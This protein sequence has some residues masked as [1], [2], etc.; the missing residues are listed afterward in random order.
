MRA[1]GA[2]GLLLLLAGSARAHELGKLEHQAL[3]D[4][5]AL[6]GLEV[7]PAPEGK[8]IAQVQVVTLEVFSARDWYFQIFNV[9]HR[10][11]REGMIRREALFSAGQPYDQALVDETW[12][13]LQHPDLSSVVV[14]VPVKSP[15]P[16][17]VDVLIVTRDVWSLRLNTEFN[18][19]QREVLALSA[20]LSENNLFGWR[21]QVALVFDM[22]QGS[23]ALGPIYID[24]N[25]AGTRLTLS[26]SASALFSRADLRSEGSR[27]GATLRYPLFSLSS[28]WGASAGVSYGNGVVRAF[29]GNHL[30]GKDFKT[31]PEV[32]RWPWIYRVRSFAT[33]TSVTRSFGARVIQRV[34]AGHAYSVV[35]PSFTPEFPQDDEARAEFAREVFPPSERVSRLALSHD[36]FTPRYVTYRDLDTFDLS[37][38]VTMGPSTSTTVSRGARWLGGDRDYYS[39]AASAGWR[40]GLGGGLQTV[41]ASW[42][43][44]FY[45]SRLQDQAYSA[46]LYLASPVLA[47][48]LRVIGSL[49]AAAYIDDTRNN[50]FALGGD[51]GLR[52]F[53]VGDLRGTSDVI[54]H[55]E[56]R[57]MALS[58]R[59]FRLGGVVFSDVGDAASPPT[60]D[61]P[62]LARAVRS[63]L[64]LNPKS[65]AGVGLRLL[66]PQLNTYVLRFDWAVPLQTTRNTP[67]G[68]PGRFTFTFRQA[69]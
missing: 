37:E 14:V 19:Q 16:G 33:S 43:G 67:A 35:R 62:D 29:T 20:S 68:L 31:T 18:I 48:R 52:G 8:T 22:D 27:A 64:R 57:S 41:S 50:Y 7:D 39:L 1:T 65:D 51:A 23:I 58:V 38:V 34:T 9:F 4:A 5:L 26:A 44:R 66:I 59:S 46:G 61:G 56:V 36:V 17:M 3:E 13:N 24:R 30:A 25:I 11:T 54:G 53:V 42:S 47:R 45:G 55:L 40:L 12:R 60:G 21:K 32:E 28:K 49:A 2:L 15:A 63:V 10:T 69:F 6:R